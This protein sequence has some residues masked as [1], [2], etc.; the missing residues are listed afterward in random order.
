[1]GLKRAGAV[2]GMKGGILNRDVHVGAKASANAELRGN[3]YARILKQLADWTRNNTGISTNTA[4]FDFPTPTGDYAAAPTLAAIYSAALGGGD[5]LWDQALSAVVAAPALG[6]VFRFP[7]GAITV[8]MVGGAIT[9]RGSKAAQEEGLV[10]SDRWLTIHTSAP[11]NNGANQA[12]AAIELPANGSVWTP[13]PAPGAQK[14]S[15]RNNAVITTGVLNTDLPDT[16]YVALRDAALNGNVLWFDAYDNYP[17]DP[18]IGD[19]F[20]FPINMITIGF[21]ID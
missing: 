13:N 8:S 21:N 7:P 11:G 2:L 17:P 5:E 20:T 1:M 16:T 15:V 3:G 4:A 19:A 10:S 6:A 18:E 14:Y 12:G 9:A